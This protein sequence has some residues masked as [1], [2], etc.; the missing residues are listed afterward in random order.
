MDSN[1][2]LRFF[3]CPCHPSEPVKRVLKQ[4]AASKIL[5]CVQ[6][7]MEA[8]SGST[9]FYVPVEVLVNEVYTSLVASKEVKIDAK[10]PESLLSILKEEESLMK[11]LADHI[12]DQKSK[13]NAQATKIER[14]L[15]EAIQKVKNEIISKLDS[16]LSAL[17]ANF[18]EFKK[19]LEKHFEYGKV[20]S[21]ISSKQ[22]IM[23]DLN[24]SLNFKE[25]EKKVRNYLIEMEE[26]ERITN[27]ITEVRE[28]VVIDGIKHFKTKLQEITNQFPESILAKEE[29]FSTQ[30]TQ[31][32]Q[33]LNDF[34]LHVGKI[35]NEIIPLRPLGIESSIISPANIEE[36]KN[37]VMPKERRLY[38]KL[39]GKLEKNASNYDE[40]GTLASTR[41]NIITIMKTHKGE[42]LGALRCPL[43]ICKEK[44]IH[45]VSFNLTKNLKKEESKTQRFTDYYVL[46]NSIFI[47]SKKMLKGNRSTHESIKTHTLAL[48]PQD[49]PALCVIHLE[50]GTHSGPLDKSYYEKRIQG[51]EE[52]EVFEVFTN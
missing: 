21:I 1:P 25:L 27:D 50:D 51:I 19:Q 22:D 42:V 6:C 43:Q 45:A 52:L 18:A 34:V 47:T 46:S 26:N 40:I 5:Y 12:Y 30:W 28:M 9:A 8:D 29:L 36:I 31:L 13:V 32:T 49:Y 7:L 20:S 4:P 10:P 2:K 35:Q 37:L 17:Q 44:D 16:Q 38:L 48:N 14:T 15:V 33:K 11:K 23:R 39:L 24:S 3:Q 41:K